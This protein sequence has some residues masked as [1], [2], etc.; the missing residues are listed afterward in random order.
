MIEIYQFTH[1]FS[2]AEWTSLAK[3]FVKVV[4]QITEQSEKELHVFN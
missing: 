3:V 4:A 2:D 1:K